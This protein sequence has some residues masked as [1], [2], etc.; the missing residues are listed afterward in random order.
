MGVARLVRIGSPYNGEE[1]AEL[2]YEQSADVM[3]LAHI[4]HPPTR[5]NRQAH[6][7]WTFS[8]ITFGPT[9]AAPA[10]VN[11]TATNPN[12]DAANGGDAYFPQVQFYSV[13]AINDET[14]QESRTA[15]FDSVNN[16]LTLK[17][18]FNTITA[19]AVTGANRYR[20]YKQDNYNS[21][22]YIG[23]S[24][25]PNFIDDNITPDLSDGPPEA[26]NPFDSA[27]NYPSSVTFHE[28][29]L[30]W[31]RTKNLPNAFW[32]SRSG[33]Y[34]NMDV[35]R[36]QRDDD[37]L[38][39]SLVAGKVNSINQLVSTQ[40]LLALA[41]DNI[42]KISGGTDSDFLSPLSIVSRR[43]IG[44]GSSRLNPLVIDNVVFYQPAVGSAIRSL[45]YSF[46]LDGVKS[47][48]V[49]IFSPHFFDGH[50]IVSWAYAQEPR[51]VIWAA[52]DD[53]KLLCFTWEQ[54]QQ[55]W[56]WTLC[57]TDGLVESVCVI[58]EGGEDRLY[59]V[60][61]RTIE[62]VDHVYI[63]RMAAA[64]WADITQACFSD[65]AVTQVFEAPQTEVLGLSHLEGCAVSVLADGYVETSHVVSGGAIELATAA[66][67]VTVGL[68]FTARVKTLPLA[69][70]G[71]DGYVTGKRQQAAQAVIRL[72]DSRGILVGVDEGNL[73]EI[74]SRLGEG[75][76]DTPDLLNGLFEIATAPVTVEE[77]T[78]WIESSYPLPMSVT[79][80]YL[81]PVA[82]T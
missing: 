74:K 55:V 65:C 78:V 60:V 54:E 69:Y 19:S 38:S 73:F 47:D 1:L 4:D 72:V 62:A 82:T 76:N 28:Q 79:A 68:P 9:I 20:F 25:G 33:D 26:R 64:R 24:T 43:Q 32:G 35:S 15:G 3:Y 39:A 70:Q 75:Y 44:R 52:R 48:D 10:G 31:G 59:L 66:T 42:F 77:T 56:G 27:G 50:T 53:G 34:E 23:Q 41:S 5:L 11:A 13:T 36:P 12:V 21:F 51:S 49:T 71:R 81:D 63:E 80:I 30:M 40:N 29:R 58:S 8:T 14:G 57:E 67:T 17:R 22:G 2:D 7:D 45:G 37:S 18:N 16:D 6:D 46:E 61:R